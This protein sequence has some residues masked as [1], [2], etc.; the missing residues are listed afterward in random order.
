MPMIAVVNIVTNGHEDVTPYIYAYIHCPYSKR[1]QQSAYR[2]P[3]N[4][5]N[6]PVAPAFPSSNAVIAK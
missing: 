5:D 3:L 1:E 2:W 6:D 4:S